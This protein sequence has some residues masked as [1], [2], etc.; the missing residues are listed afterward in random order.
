METGAEDWS[1]SSTI[2]MPL[3]GVLTV[4]VAAGKRNHSLCRLEVSWQPVNKRERTEFSGNRL[5]K[6]KTRGEG[7]Q[8][9]TVK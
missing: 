6:S 5:E 3:A 8:K 9:P 4:H 7:T 1:G 2:H